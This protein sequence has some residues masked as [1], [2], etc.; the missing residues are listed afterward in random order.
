[1]LPGP[2]AVTM[3]VRI[4]LLHTMYPAVAWVALRTEIGIHT[5]VPNSIPLRVER[6]IPLIVEP[7]MV[8]PRIVRGEHMFPQYVVALS[9]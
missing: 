7:W 5:V 8:C 6:S 9:G 1:M 3:E 2:T 4:A